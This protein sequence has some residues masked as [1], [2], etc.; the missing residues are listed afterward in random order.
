MPNN[1]TTQQKA[2]MGKRKNIR[3]ISYSCTGKN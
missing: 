3:S 1:E 2:Q